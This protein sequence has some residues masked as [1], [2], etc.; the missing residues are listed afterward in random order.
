LHEPLA[1]TVDGL[2][3]CQDSKALSELAL[4]QD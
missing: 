2:E 1:Q 4:T 3:Q